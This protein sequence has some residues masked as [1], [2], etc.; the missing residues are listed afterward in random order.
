MRIIPLPVKLWSGLLVAV[1]FLFPCSI[2]VPIA[3]AVVTETGAGTADE[4][5][6]YGVASSWLL[7]RQLFVDGQTEDALPYLHFAYRSQP[8]VQAIAMTFQEALADGGYLRDAL[9]VMDGLVAAWPDSLSFLLRRSSLNLQAGHRDKA[10]KD[11]QEIRRKGLGTPEVIS[12]EATLLAAAGNPERA[13]DVFREG[14]ELFPAEATRFYMGMVSIHQQEGKIERIPA[15]MDEALII[16][17]NQPGLWLVKIRSLAAMERHDDA[18]ACVKN[19]TTQFSTF[20]TAQRDSNELAALIRS[21]APAPDSA[22][23]FYIEI[24]LLLREIVRRDAR[25]DCILVEGKN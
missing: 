19:A 5:V 1:V 3:G 23:F 14:L 25:L 12:A 4:D 11:L 8:D 17:R 15:L 24:H 13:L 9:E 18:L 10:L 7:G 20:L 21:G 6:P 16:N 22:E 2:L